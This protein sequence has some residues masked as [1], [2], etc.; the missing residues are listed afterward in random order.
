MKKVS[1]LSPCNQPEIR[2]IILSLKNKKS[3]GHDGISNLL[4]KDLVDVLTISSTH[5]SLIKCLTQGIFPDIMKIA[6]VVPLHK[7]GNIHMVDNYRPISL[8][9]TIS[10]ILEKLVYNRVYT[11]LNKTNQFMRASTASVAN[12]LVNM[13]YQN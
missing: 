10:K 12:T 6:D 7:N 4:L 2:Q 1:F 11:F 13:L 5:Y 3:S 9:M 8:L